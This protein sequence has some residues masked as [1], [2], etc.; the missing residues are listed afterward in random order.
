MK[1][2]TK[3]ICLVVIAIATAIP[4]LFVGLFDRSEAKNIRAFYDKSVESQQL[5][6]LISDDILTYWNNAIH[7]GEFNGN[8]DTAIETALSENGKNLKILQENDV[9]IKTLYKKIRESQYSNEAKAVI[10][11][12]SEY[13]LLV[14]NANGSFDDFFTNKESCKNAL[15]VAL[16]KLSFEIE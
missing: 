6:N 9:K 3:K 14:I 8:V 12:Y 5:L 1:D 4:L 15:A 11:A 2:A 13:Y 10:D 16:K 7:E